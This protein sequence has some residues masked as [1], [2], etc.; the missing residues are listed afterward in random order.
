M[1]KPAQC[2]AFPVFGNIALLH[3]SHNTLFS[4]FLLAKV[5]AQKS[6]FIRIGFGLYGENTA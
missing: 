1:M 2:V 4:K 5:P 6:P 3:I